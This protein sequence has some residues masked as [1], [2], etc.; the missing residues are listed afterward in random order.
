MPK[1]GGSVVPLCTHLPEAKAN[2]SGECLNTVLPWR[3]GGNYLALPGPEGGCLARTVLPASCS[4][5][6]AVA[7]T[8]RPLE[9]GRWHLRK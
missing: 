7:P 4:D 1:R 2:S 5:E 9:L 8:Q 6:L 3:R